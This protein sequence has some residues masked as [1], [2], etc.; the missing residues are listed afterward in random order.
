A[1]RSA[2]PKSIPRNS[3]IPDFQHM[4]KTIVSQCTYGKNF[5][6]LLSPQKGFQVI[7]KDGEV[8]LVNY[9]EGLQTEPP[10]HG[11]CN[12][13][14]YAVGQKVRHILGDKFVVMA[15]KGTCEE[16]FP[17]GIHYFILPWPQ[18]KDAKIQS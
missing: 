2:K 14:T 3:F 16:F 12:D 7:S 15:A 4:I 6:G 8:E 18:P 17:T 11:V 1:H 13:L 9:E 5:L 10:Y